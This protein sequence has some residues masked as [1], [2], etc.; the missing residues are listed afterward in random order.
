MDS[1][2]AK[3]MRREDRRATRKLNMSPMLLYRGILSVLERLKTKAAARYWN[4]LRR[5]VTLVSSDR[6]FSLVSD[7]I[8][9][10]GHPSGCSKQQAAPC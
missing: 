8:G 4:R 1:P 7:L 2:S 10:S 9:R 5:N 6:M 3:R